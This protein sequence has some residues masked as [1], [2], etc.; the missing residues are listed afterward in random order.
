MT[1]MPNRKMPS[2]PRGILSRLV[3]DQMASTIRED[4]EYRR[5]RDRAEKGLFAAFFR[6]AGRLVA[7]LGPLLAYAFQGEFVMLGNSIKM[8]RRQLAKH[9]G[10]SFINI[11]GLALGMAA[12]LFLV[13]WVQD[14]LSFDAFHERAADIF[15]VHNYGAWTPYP[16]GPDAG[17]SIPEIE[18]TVRQTRL[19][20]AV[21]RVG[22]KTFYEDR[23]Q[24]VDPS[25]LRVF[26]FPLRQGDAETALSRPHALILTGRSHGPDRDPERPV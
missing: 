26:T 20:T 8:A 7:T 25:F 16:L 14:E 24:A 9:K 17:R 15:R 6:H 22:E 19:G 10:F 4:L 2:N 11:T 1:V 13:L 18:D 23:V 3:D 12:C 21:L 5:S